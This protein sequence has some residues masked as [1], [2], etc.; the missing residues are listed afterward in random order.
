MYTQGPPQVIRSGGSNA[1]I[2]F[3]IL[4]IMVGIGAYAYWKRCELGLEDCEKEEEVVVEPPEPAVINGCMDP[5]AFNYDSTATSNVN[6]CEYRYDALNAHLDLKDGKWDHYRTNITNEDGTKKKFANTEE[7]IN[8]TRREH[9][10]AKMV[11]YRKMSDPDEEQQGTCAY[12]LGNVYSDTNGYYEFEKAEHRVTA[13][14]ATNVNIRAGCAAPSSMMYDYLHGSHTN[15]G[16]DEGKQIGQTNMVEALAD[17]TFQP[18]DSHSATTAYKKFDSAYECVDHFKANKP[19]VQMVTYRKQHTDPT[20]AKTCYGY[21]MNKYPTTE[22]YLKIKART[23]GNEYLTMCTGTGKDVS[24]GCEGDKPV[25]I[26]GGTGSSS[27]TESST[28]AVNGDPV[29]L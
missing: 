25:A 29:V 23:D 15:E 24:Q 19:D 26:V 14:T 4:L 13:C 6:S 12:M 10:N 1:P 17:G 16:Q 28:I 11:M 2:I 5:L 3:M 21:N 18:R 22:K 8:Y 20:W 9:P 7:C 27:S